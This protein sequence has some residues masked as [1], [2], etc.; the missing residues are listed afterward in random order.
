[1]WDTCIVRKLRNK[2]VAWKSNSLVWHVGMPGDRVHTPY[3]MFLYLT[4]YIWLEC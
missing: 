1:M 4:V 2:F 3:L